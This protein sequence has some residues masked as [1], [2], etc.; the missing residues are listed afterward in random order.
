MEIRPRHVK[1]KNDI[2]FATW[3]VL[4]LY[5]PGSFKRSK[6]QIHKY[7][8]GLTALGEI[9]WKGTGMMDAGNYTLFHT[10]N[11]NN[12]FG[13]GFMVSKELK[14]LVLGFT[15]IN[16]RLCSIRMKF[17]FFSI[18]IICAHAPIEDADEE[19]KDTFYL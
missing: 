3:N 15:P 14:K 6:E 4:S 12:T 17:K 18:T 7:R 16:E 19:V 5:Q 13:T 10:G 2:R 11:T 8:I 9:R 1:W